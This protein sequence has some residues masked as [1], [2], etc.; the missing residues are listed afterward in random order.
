MNFFF[1]ANMN[2]RYARMIS[3]LCED[4]HEIVHIT[5]HVDFIHNNQY[6]R[7]GRVCGNHTPDVE[8]ISSLGQSGKEWKI[9][10]GESDIIDTAHE[11]A[12]LIKSRLTFFSMDHN[13]GKASAPEQAWK[14]VKVWE[15][16]AKCA[17]VTTP[18]LYRVRM[19]KQLNIEVIAGGHRARGGRFRT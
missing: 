3:A 6:S 4:F 12:E 17:E 2:F 16:L 18:T 11:R 14:L 10:S 1:D 7:N 13:W 8:W 19:G 9:I 5:E 15:Q